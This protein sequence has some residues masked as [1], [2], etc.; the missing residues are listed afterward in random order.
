MQP[1][2][3]TASVDYVADVAYMDVWFWLKSLD[4]TVGV[5]YSLKK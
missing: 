1:A 4:L 2:Q 3:M 5:I